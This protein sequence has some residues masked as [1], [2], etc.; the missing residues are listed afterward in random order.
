MT[1]ATSMCRGLASGGRRCRTPAPAAAWPLVQ[2][3]LDVSSKHT[4]VGP[5][6]T[7]G[8]ATVVAA[9]PPAVAAAAARGRVLQAGLPPVYRPDAGNG[10]GGRVRFSTTAGA[11]AATE[12][13][14]GPPAAKADKGGGGG[15]G[16]GAQSGDGE[17]ASTVDENPLGGMV[18][19]D[20]DPGPPP[21][22]DPSIVTE[23]S[24]KVLEVMASIESLN[25]VEMAMLID[26]FKNKLGLDELPTLSF[27]GADGGGESGGGD[28]DAPAA[29]AEKTIF[30]VKVTGFGDKAKIKVI[31]EVRVITGLGLREAKEMVESLPQVVKEDLKE[32]EAEA[33]KAK[34][35][36]VGA[37]VELE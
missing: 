22:L 16:S 37:T 4:A 21:P 6:S 8:C 35:E 25:F 29:A 31:K 32:D 9:T 5:S 17:A 7:R 1:L 28:E 34:L 30:K 26:L 11:D 13:T 15:G 18:D 27:G 36:A 20:G 12:D 14:S 24:P 3:G 19:D 2:R 23:P 33:M 10:N